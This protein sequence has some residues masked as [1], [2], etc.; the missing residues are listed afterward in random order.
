[1]DGTRACLSF[2]HLTGTFVRNVLDNTPLSPVL[3][4]ARSVENVRSVSFKSNLSC[5]KLHR[6]RMI[7]GLVDGTCSLLVLC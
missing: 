2:D 1:M 4:D 7:C 6:S 5:F 3:P